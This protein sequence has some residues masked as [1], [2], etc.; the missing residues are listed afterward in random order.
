MKRRNLLMRY[1]AWIISWGGK[2]RKN[3][4]GYWKHYAKHTI[5]TLSKMASRRNF[6]CIRRN[7]MLLKCKKELHME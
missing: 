2:Q 4:S 7:L 6:D 1:F 5:E 3:P